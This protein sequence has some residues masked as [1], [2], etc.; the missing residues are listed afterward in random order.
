MPRLKYITSE[1]AARNGEEDDVC[2]IEPGER[3]FTDSGDAMRLAQDA[4]IPVIARPRIKAW[5]SCVP[6]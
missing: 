6:P 2:I 1:F 4:A 3:P 5:K